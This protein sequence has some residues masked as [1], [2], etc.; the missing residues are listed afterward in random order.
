MI[1][2]M[3]RELVRLSTYV[4]FRRIEVV[5][6]EHIPSE[7]PVI[8]FGNHPNSLLDP[9]LITAFGERK[10]H[11]AAKDT[12]FSKPLLGYILHKMGAVP[13][14]RKQDHSEGPL[15]NN[16]AFSALYTL[17]GRGEAM[18]IF[19][20]GISHN[21]TQLAELK[22]GAARIALEMKRK[23][24]EVQLV[25]CGLTYLKKKRF[26]ASVL[27]Q[28]G[29]PVQM[30]EETDDPR[31]LTRQLELALRSLTVNAETWEDLALLDTVRRLYQ[32]KEATLE[33]RVELARRFNAHYP[34]IR[35]LPEI[36]A[37]ARE[38]DDYRDDLF[39][40]GVRDREIAG[41][42]TPR[43]FALKS[44]KHILLMTVW[45]P[46]AL[47]GAPIHLPLSLSLGF[48]SVLIAPRKDVIA[49][50]KFLAGILSLLGI[51]LGS[52]ILAWWY[53]GGGWSI[54]AP[55]S[56]ALSG[57]GTLKMAE[58]GRALGRTL[59]IGSRH[60]MARRTLED[61]RQRR[62]ELRMKVLK[63]VD[64]HLPEGMERLFYSEEVSDRSLIDK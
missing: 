53:G 60:F 14:K 6:I 16:E 13:I 19:P 54:L 39:S 46:L 44:V 27:I 4:F 26:R 20:E 62:E 15:D 57:W 56:L 29:P 42:L 63:L 3:I 58:R 45:C 40:L 2:W 22:T 59:W 47:I 32:P 25:P 30:T 33:Q 43:K 52:G 31:E 48:G 12:L 64:L 5:G 61:M 28:F 35:E 49:T 9:A 23:N 36:S 8:F 24:V 55:I 21:G 11:F 17:L 18:G 34:A 7:G 38:L 51:Y 1:Y 41:A 37:L 50:T 10:L